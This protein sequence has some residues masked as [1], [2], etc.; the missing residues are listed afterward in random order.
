MCGIC[1]FFDPELKDKDCAIQGMMDTI[2]HRGPSSDGKYTNDQVALGFRRL[3]IIDLRGGSQPIFNEDKS[4][5]IIFNGEIYNFKPLRKELIDAGHTF[6]TKAD[7]EV[8]LHGYEEWGMD[9]LLKRVR[10]MFAFVIW[11]DNT[12][13]LYGARDFFGIKPMYYSD[14]NGK[15]IVGSELK[16]FL[17]YP[18]F[19]KELNTEAV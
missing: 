13:T 18:G 1:A 4:R 9:G 2:K 10:G 17:A 12:K 19:K 16:S 5:A 7:T 6:T 15:L 11:D 8:L 3:S 14:Q